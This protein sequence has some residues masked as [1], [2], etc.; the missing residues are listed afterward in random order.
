MNPNFGW[1]EDPTES[2]RVTALLY[3]KTTAQHLVADE[4]K[5]VVLSDLYTKVTGPDGTPAGPQ[6]IGDCV[7]WGWGNLCNIL[8]CMQI[9]DIIRAEK[10]DV[11]EK[12]MVGEKQW[13]DNDVVKDMGL[14]YREVAT[15]SIYGFSRCEVGKQWNSYD[16][17]SVGA[18][19][20]KACEQYGVLSRKTVGAY[21]SQ[22]AKQW[23][24]KGVP[25]N[26]E[27]EAK[28]NVIKAA[29]KITDY[30]V[31]AA[32]IQGGQPVAVC[33]DRGF[34][35]TRDNQGFAAPSGVWGHCMLFMGVR[36]DRPGLLCMQSWG[37]T[38][39]GGPLALSQP[40]NTFWVDQNVAQYMLSKNDSF[41]GT[42]INGWRSTFDWTF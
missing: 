8:Q 17:G 39:P 10:M 9:L 6:G 42:Y 35:L 24:A 11:F 37:K 26:F 2:N 36:W 38:N 27:A 41:A 7:S 20:A 19:A 12:I 3:G 30:K 28:I 1:R 13:N 25:D 16:D 5:N 15:E 4:N 29:D 21:D 34:T 23:G 40:T 31:A 14:D 18:W 32:S 33:S 22:R